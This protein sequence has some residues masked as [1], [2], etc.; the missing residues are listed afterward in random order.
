MLLC[1]Y[2]IAH[3]IDYVIGDSSPL[4]PFFSS[5]SFPFSFPILRNPYNATML[6]FPLSRCYTVR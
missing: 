4:L 1:S 2:D 5:F 6:Y 3:E